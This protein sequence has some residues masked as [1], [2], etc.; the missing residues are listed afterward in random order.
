MP[1]SSKLLS[2]VHLGHARVSDQSGKRL[3]GLVGSPWRDPGAEASADEIGGA[4]L[5]FAR[6]SSPSRSLQCAGAGA[7]RP[8][9]P[10]G[11]R[12]SGFIISRGLPTWRGQC[13]PQ[14]SQIQQIHAAGDI[15][16]TSSAS[17][18]G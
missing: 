1:A 4:C 18:R 9:N 11:C 2:S 8:P 16:E 6:N 17:E 14:N 13:S 12:L 5:H 7:T 10:R 3:K 15:Y